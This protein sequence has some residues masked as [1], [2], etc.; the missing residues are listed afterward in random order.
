MTL[1]QQ[2]KAKAAEL[3]PVY[4]KLQELDDAIDSADHIDAVMFRE[5]EYL[6][7][8]AAAILAMIEKGY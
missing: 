2:F 3:M 8:I 6:G 4:S 1:A 7:G 5:S